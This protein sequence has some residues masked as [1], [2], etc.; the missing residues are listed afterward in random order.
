MISC[1]EAAHICTKKQYEE[2]TWK[3]RIQLF[4]HL[5]VCKTCTAFSRKNAQLTSLCKK[6]HLQRL[7]DEEKQQ[8]KIRLQ[9]KG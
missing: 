5:V 9:N 2:A 6:A 3:E 4:L 7:S 1:K 8:M